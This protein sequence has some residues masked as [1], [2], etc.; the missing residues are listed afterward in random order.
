[1]IGNI[2][3]TA[4]SGLRA[5]SR[6]L[7]ASAANTANLRTTGA[8]PA[9]GGASAVAYQ[10]V[11]ATQSSA[12]GGGVVSGFR[13]ITPGYIPEYDPSSAAADADGMVAAPNV[14]PITETV[15][16]VQGAAAYRMNLKIFAASD[17]MTKTL[18]DIGA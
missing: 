6:T 15:T 16:Q 1:M 17:E 2:T 4:M 14:D 13:P 11:R 10:P 9:S 7:E 12:P 5:S 18:L 3:T 8:L